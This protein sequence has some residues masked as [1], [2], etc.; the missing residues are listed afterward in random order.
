M[1][2]G[3]SNCFNSPS[4]QNWADHHLKGP[5]TAVPYNQLASSSGTSFIS[6]SNA[7][8]ESVV[9]PISSLKKEANTKRTPEE[10][11]IIQ[12]TAER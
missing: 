4:T 7:S 3:F 6:P 8:V 2:T 12:A 1:S 5:V 11:D 9:N 10:L